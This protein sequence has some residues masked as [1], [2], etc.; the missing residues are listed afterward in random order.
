[1]NLLPCGINNPCD[2]E[3]GTVCLLWDFSGELHLP[4]WVG[5]RHV[6]DKEGHPSGEHTIQKQS[7][8]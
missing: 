2:S 6:G 7:R 3:T 5:L 1:M 8:G 4:I